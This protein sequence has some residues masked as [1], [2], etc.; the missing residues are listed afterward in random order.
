MRYDV[1]VPRSGFSVRP[2]D[3]PR[4]PP[5]GQA[6]SAEAEPDL[7]D[8][9]ELAAI[10]AAVA[11]KPEVMPAPAAGPL[12]TPPPESPAA[13]PPPGRRRMVRRL[14]EIPVLLA[15]ALLV[16]IVIK[17]FLVQAY[18]I[19]SESMVPALEVGDR[20]LVEKVSFRFRDPQRGEIIV[21][22]HPDAAVEGGVPTVVRSFFEDLGLV[23]PQQEVA[24]IKRVVG[25]PGETIT[26][27]D[28]TVMV[29]GRALAE[30]TVVADRRSFPAFTVPADSYYMLG[31][32][33]GNSDDSRYSL[34][35][36][37]REE[38]V[39]RAFVVL[40]P[41]G[42]ASLSLRTHYAGDQPSPDDGRPALNTRPLALPRPDDAPEAPPP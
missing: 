12:A 38:V 28:G 29:D 42:N 25:L 41:P 7:D 40:W 31:D 11:A 18:Y 21:F 16:A 24:L 27:H 34:G 17:S 6:R 14:V 37:P 19:P 13:D 26:V 9:E 36:V 1:Y 15:G 23:R 20:V 2:P 4:D 10:P 39:G 22:E 32:N 35:A 30:G 3:L 8:T 5:D 33:R